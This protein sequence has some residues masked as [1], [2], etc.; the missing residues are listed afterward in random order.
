MTPRTREQDATRPEWG[1]NDGHS[2]LNSDIPRVDGP[3]KVTGRAVY[4]HDIRLPDMGYAR[5]VVCPYP[6][7]VIKT[8]SYR[9]AKGVPGVVHAESFKEDGDQIAVLGASN[10]SEGMKV[11]PLGK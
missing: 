4:T 6:R 11:R 7:A 8:Q 10:L 2:L 9:K 3:E 1:A 5:L